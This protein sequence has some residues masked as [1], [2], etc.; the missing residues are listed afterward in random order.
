MRVL[1]TLCLC[2][3]VLMQFLDFSIANVCIPYIAGDL[4]VAT[5][6]GTYVITLFAVGNAIGLPITGWITKR[7]GQIKTMVCSIMLFT[8]WSWICGISQ[9]LSMLC[10]ARFIQ[11]FV[12]GPLIPLSQSLMIK[13]YPN[14]KKNLALAI[15]NTVAL[16]GPIGGPIVGGWIVYNYTWP[17]IFFINIPMGLASAIGVYIALKGLE[18]NTEK[19]P[20]DWIGFLLLAVAVT[21][22][23]L[24]LDKGQQW[25]WLRSL[26]IRAL[27]CISLVSFIYFLVWELN[28]KHP[29]VDLSLF[30]DR[31]FT[32]STVFVS[33]SYMII[34]GAIVLTP[35]WLQ[36]YMGYVAYWAGLAVAPMG[37][38]A[39][40]LMPMVPIF[41]A[42]TSLRN[43]IAISFFFFGIGLL[44]FSLYTTA[45][46]VAFISCTRLLFG[47][48]FIFYLGPLTVIAVSRIP[49]EKLNSA[50]GIYHFWRILFGGIG[51]SIFTTMFQRRTIFHHH[52][53]IETVN[54][55]RHK[56]PT[57]L[58]Y[59]GN[60]GLD[61]MQSLDTLNMMVDKQAAILAQNDI[62]WVA[63]WLILALVPLSFLF[64]KR[65]KTNLVEQQGH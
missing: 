26:R 6:Q 31:N 39:L 13:I 14:E 55:Y 11:G 63:G 24:I 30:K 45:V 22:F 65:P 43:L 46:S 57:F 29:I 3:G 21:C 34:M 44:S 35:L 40:L 23:Q 25:D 51:A 64:R 53:L 5:D 47:M 50:S 17:W 8:L 33:V 42:R 18:T 56:I 20:V 12:A 32:M 52:N 54:D 61:P 48:G 36:E 60:Q 16:I 58:K 37:Y 10:V 2:F 41:M 38:A 4:A 9:S 15:W 7:Y 1:A 62:Y 49:H 59:L 19:L 27:S 28:E